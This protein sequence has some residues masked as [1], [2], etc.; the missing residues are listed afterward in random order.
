MGIETKSKKE[1]EVP[2]V[3]LDRLHNL[4]NLAAGYTALYNDYLD[5]LKGWRKED[6]R[7]CSEMYRIR[8]K[9]TGKKE[10]AEG[11]MKT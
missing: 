1:A 11:R 3:V 2:T 4:K 9:S 6:D 7:R 8:R 10:K 5:I